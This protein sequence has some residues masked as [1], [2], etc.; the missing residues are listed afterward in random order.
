MFRF[1]VCSS[2]LLAFIFRFSCVDLTSVRSCSD[3]R[4]AMSRYSPVHQNFLPSVF[5]AFVSRHSCFHGHTLM[6]SWS[7]FNAFPIHL[8]F[9]VQTFVCS[10]DLL[11][12]IFRF[13]CVDLTS[14]RSCSDFRA[15]V[16]RYS[17][18]H[19]NFLPS[20]FCAFVSRHS[21]F[22]GHTLM[23]SWSDFNAFP[24][25]LC[26]HVQTFVRWSDLLALMFRFSC[27]HV[28]TFACSPDFCAFRLLCL[29]V[30]TFVCSWS[31]PYAFIFRF[32]CVHQIFVRSPHF[33]AL[34][35]RLSCGHI[36]IFSRSPDFLAF[37]FLCLRVQTFVLS[38]S[39]PY[40]LMIR[41]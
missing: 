18:V 20:V 12:F 23:N 29:R 5:C 33:R 7:D 6:N 35:F 24:I 1:F 40:E 36:Q 30:Q 31:Y 10:S 27:G 39:Y 19:Q 13:S 9:H 21:C 8:C 28:Q 2:D 41:L 26:I 3:F 11:A 4:A 38:W 14:V 34:M 22:H 25:H 15:A 32:L 16:S 17:P 37:S